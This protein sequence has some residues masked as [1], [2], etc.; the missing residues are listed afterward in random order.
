MKKLTTPSDTWYVKLFTN[1]SNTA[2]GKK[3]IELSKKY[4]E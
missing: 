3:L 2:A 4:V 1:E